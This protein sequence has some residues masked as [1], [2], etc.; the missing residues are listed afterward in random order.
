[1]GEPVSAAI[2]LEIEV[3]SEMAAERVPGLG[4]TMPQETIEALRDIDDSI[5]SAEQLSGSLIFG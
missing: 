5:R 4:W 1:M 2:D 3:S